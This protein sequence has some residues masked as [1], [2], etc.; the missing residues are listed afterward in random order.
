MAQQSCQSEGTTLSMESTPEL[1]LSSKSWTPGYMGV[2]LTPHPIIKEPICPSPQ[3]TW[4]L[5]TAGTVSCPTRCRL[6]ALSLLAQPCVCPPHPLPWTLAATHRGA[7]SFLCKI[8]M[9]PT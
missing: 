3:K 8:K 4:P 9:E 7:C 1:R 5:L 2:S 6:H